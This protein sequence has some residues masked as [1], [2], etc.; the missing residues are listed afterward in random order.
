MATRSSLSSYRL[1]RAHCECL[2]DRLSLLLPWGT[3]VQRVR[4]TWDCDIDL[5]SPLSPSWH[6]PNKVLKNDLVIPVDGCQTAVELC[7]S[8]TS[9]GLVHKFKVVAQIIKLYHCFWWCVHKE[10]P[11]GRTSRRQGPLKV[12][13]HHSS[14]FSDHNIPVSLARVVN[15]R[16]CHER[17]LFPL[18]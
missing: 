12:F 11:I 10:T 3:S 18:E 2:G 6:K 17:Y 7:P 1:W 13:T 16:N 8:E 14:S 4:F 5:Y 15:T 9:F